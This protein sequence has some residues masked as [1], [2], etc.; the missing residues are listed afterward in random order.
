VLH[1]HEARD[2][3]VTTYLPLVRYVVSR[4]NV[5]L[6]PSLE[7]ADL[8]GFGTVGLIDAV[9]RFDLERGF[10]FQTFA[11][12]RIRGAILDELRS[13]DW[14]PRSLRSRMHTIDRATVTFEQE[15]GCEPDINDL[16]AATGLATIDI[17]STL[18]AYKSGYVTSLDERMLSD[19]SS[20]E[21]ATGQQFVDETEELPDEIFDH[22]ESQRIM[23]RHIRE[24]KA[25]DRAVIALY[26]FEELTLAEIGRVLGVSESRAC[27][28]HGRA[29]R[30]LRQ[31]TP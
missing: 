24:L 4:L 17:R 30:D 10:T 11:V 29:I 13:S 3:L 20:G 7:R 8:V 2:V 9:S 31:A 16:A 26:Y 25:R 6:P 28:I 5:T 1:S 19:G 21:G 12:T 27:Q 23:R 15:H 18:A 22:A 14:V